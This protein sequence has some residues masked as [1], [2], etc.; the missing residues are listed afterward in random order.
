MR[1]LIR[2]TVQDHDR[3]AAIDRSASSYPWPET[4]LH[5]SLEREQVLTL[6]HRDEAVGFL[7]ED[8]VLDETTLLHL[9]VDAAHQG[10]GHARWALQNWLTDL[11]RSGQTRCLLEVRSGNRVAIRLYES[12]GFEDIGRRKGY[13]ASPDGAED[14]RVMA[15]SLTEGL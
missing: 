8:R 11:A 4:A 1:R 2:A 6:Q 5:R 10:R 9:A 13:Y 15:R 3:L 12:L 7:V 14:A